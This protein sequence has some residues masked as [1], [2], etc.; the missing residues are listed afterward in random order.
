MFTFTHFETVIHIQNN[1]IDVD[2]FG[3]YKILNKTGILVVG[4][5][6]FHIILFIVMKFK[7]L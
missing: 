3:F 4:G 1:R 5:K 6:L 7:N 2:Y